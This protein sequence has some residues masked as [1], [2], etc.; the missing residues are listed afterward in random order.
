[1]TAG[2]PVDATG[3]P[4]LD[5]A[6]DMARRAVPVAA[7][8]VLASTIGWGA[9]GAASSLVAVALVVLNFLAAAGLIAWGARISLKMLMA[10]VLGGYIVRLGL[11]TLALLA[12]KDAAWVARAPLFTTLLVTHV[13]LLL[14]EVRHVSASLAFPGLAPRPGR[15]ATDP[16]A[17]DPNAI[18]KEAARS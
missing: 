12:V 13:G 4:E 5:V 2:P 3:T 8:L 16:N 18:D 7:V 14:W 9:E 1:V 17:T 10:A 15:D 6:W 11:L